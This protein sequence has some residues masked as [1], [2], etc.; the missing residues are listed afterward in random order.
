MI[1]LPLLGKF[2]LLSETARLARTLGT[3]LDNGIPLYQSLLVLKDSMGNKVFARAIREAGEK[4]REGGG[5]SDPLDK[6][7]VFPPLFIQM[8]SVGEETGNLEMMLFKAADTYEKQVQAT[9]KR[10]TALMEPVMIL[11]L[12]ALVGFIVISMLLAIFSIND[13]PF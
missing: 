12:G 4:L 9:V 10:L 6:T 13:I 3:L 11:L 2:F 8:I 7:E 1:R 5:I